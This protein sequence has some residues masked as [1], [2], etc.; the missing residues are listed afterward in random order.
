MK[1]AHLLLAIICQHGA[2]LPAADATRPNIIFI[3]SD[4]VGLG[5]IS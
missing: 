1:L 2:H 5:N 3:L 4:D